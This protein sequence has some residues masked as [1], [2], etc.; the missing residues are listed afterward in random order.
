MFGTSNI[1][2][3]SFNFPEIPDSLRFVSGYADLPSSSVTKLRRLQAQRGERRPV[4]LRQ[5]VG[6]ALHQGRL[7]VRAHRQLA[8]RR[9]AVPVDQPQLG[10]AAQRARRPQRARHLRP[11]HGDA[12]STTPATSTPTASAL[13]LQDAWTVRPQPHAQSRPAHRQ[14]RDSVVHRRAIA[15]S[16]SASRTR[17]RRAPGSRGTSSATASGRPTAASGS[18]TTPRSSRCRAASFGS[19]HSITYYMTARHLQL[20]VDPVRPSAG[21]RPELP[22]HVHR[23]G[24]LPSCGERG[25]QLPDRSGPQADSDARVHASASITR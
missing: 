2:S 3:A 12:A 20:A 5:Q 19:E 16:S 10:L 24:R 8:A 14:G 4:V 22:G 11:L 17:S 7:P 13:F 9:R 21:A 18:S 25:R 15:A 1:Q 23:A 6:P